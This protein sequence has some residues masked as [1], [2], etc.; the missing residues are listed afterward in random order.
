M[1]PWLEREAVRR[2]GARAEPAGRAVG[3]RR[4]AGASTVLGPSGM[5][6]WLSK[7]VPALAGA[8]TIA[9]DGRSPPAADQ[10]RR[11]DIAQWLSVRRSH[12]RSRAGPSGCR[13]PAPIRHERV[14]ACARRRTEATAAS[15][16][17]RAARSRRRHWS[18]AASDGSVGSARSAC[19]P[20]P[21]P[22]MACR[23]RVVAV[24][25]RDPPTA[26]RPRG[27]SRGRASR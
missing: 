25:D 10:R 1:P 9:A 14:Q 12:R 7:P 16:D 3:D 6:V 11:S 8:P 23:G 26:A 19:T 24:A 2:R 27:G 15:G 20:R 13:W 17:G 4:G 21:E 18:P 5:P 22:D